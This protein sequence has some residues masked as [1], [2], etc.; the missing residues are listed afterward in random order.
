MGRNTLKLEGDFLR[1][2]MGSLYR[3]EHEGAKTVIEKAMIEAEQRVQMDTH[4]A[5]TFS[6]LPAHGKYST[7]K[8][9][10][11]IH[12]SV[13]P[14]WEGGVAWVPV[15]FD[16]NKPGA[17]GYLISGT[18]RMK[19]DV[20][21]QKIYRT[22]GYMQEIQKQIFEQLSDYIQEQWEKAT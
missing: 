9:S 12:D 6:N 3:L 14:T 18:P 17:G 5:I 19:P 15:G 21:L 2:L 8:T 4:L 22:K 7:G 20:A 10:E 16:F 13:P 11:A 1:P